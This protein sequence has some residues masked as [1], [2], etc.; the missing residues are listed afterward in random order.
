M[1]QMVYDK[2]RFSMDDKMGDADI[3]IG[4]LLE[5]LRSAK[6]GGLPVGAVITRIQPSRDICL[7]EESCIVRD[8]QGG[9]TQSMI[10]RLRNVES[11]E[12]ELEFQ[13]IDVPG[14]RGL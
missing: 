11:G 4:P 2:D 8:D 13:W 1:L 14:S 10:L 7:A 12:V 5:A 9:L 3:H 6:L